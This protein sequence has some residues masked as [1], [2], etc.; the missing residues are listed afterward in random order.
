MFLLITLSLLTITKLYYLIHLTSL[1]TFTRFFKSE[2]TN[3]TDITYRQSTLYV[4]PF[5][6]ERK[7]IEVQKRQSHNTTYDYSLISFFTSTHTDNKTRTYP[8]FKE[9]HL[10]HEKH[11]L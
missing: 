2:F 8:P 6:L 4:N 7:P 9:M 3:M 11:T 10:K 1:H 5:K